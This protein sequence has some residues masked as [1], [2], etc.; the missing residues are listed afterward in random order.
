M[1]HIKKQYDS[2]V[3]TLILS[4]LLLTLSA[5]PS[6][7]MSAKSLTPGQELA[8]AINKAGRQRM[9]SQR[10]LK[11]YSQIILRVR[12][13]DARKQ[14]DKA[15]SLFD[16]QLLWLKTVTPTKA[17]NDQLGKVE[18]IWGQYKRIVTGPVNRAG[19]EKL[20]PLSE[21]LLTESHHV[22][23]QFQ[24]FVGGT[25]ARMVNLSGRQRMLSQR[26]AMFFMLSELGFNDANITSGMSEAMREFDE[27]HKELLKSEL[28]TIEINTE[29]KKTDIQWQLFR[30]SIKN[31][32][33]ISYALFVA[34]TSEKVLTLM[35]K[36][37][38]MY[39]AVMA[40]DNTISTPQ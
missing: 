33:A 4:A 5:L 3:L 23:V 7:V 32:D 12:D 13:E 1:R 18:K 6:Q 19:A 34:L 31:R 40:S 37:T 25:S 11:S 38:G 36:I 26:V 14:L 2:S 24:N 27:A 30:H 21:Q 22:V 28:N 10:M 8:A 20:I 9:L 15:V 17:I 39:E 35:N 29:L 16:G